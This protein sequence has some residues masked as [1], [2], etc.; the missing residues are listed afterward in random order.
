MQKN[1][2]PRWAQCSLLNYF[3]NLN[4][5]NI[6]IKISLYIIVVWNLYITSKCLKYN[7]YFFKDMKYIY[8]S[9][10]LF[11]IDIYSYL[12]DVGVSCL[13][14][15]TWN[16]VYK[17]PSDQIHHCSCFLVRKMKIFFNLLQFDNFPL[18]ILPIN[19][20]LFD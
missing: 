19:K 12:I 9:F 5:F 15:V 8:L 1:L 7:W 4:F 18:L 14:C 10:Y 6:F 2:N 16:Y 11:I 3:F 20:F 13:F 17:Y